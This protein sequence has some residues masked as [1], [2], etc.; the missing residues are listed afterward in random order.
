MNIFKRREKWISLKVKAFWI[1]LLGVLI[2]GLLIQAMIIWVVQLSVK[3]IYIEFAEDTEKILMS[4]LDQNSLKE[5]RNETLE[6]F[7][8]VSETAKDS[9]DAYATDEY[10]SLY[11]TLK[12][13]P[14]Y[15]EI[16]RV[17]HSFRHR[18]DFGAITIMAYD[19]D[20]GAFVVM[21]DSDYEKYQYPLGKRINRHEDYY[22]KTG[23][24]IEPFLRSL[25]AAGPMITHIV[26]IRDRNGKLL[27]YLSV[28]IKDRAISND[29]MMTARVTL[30][31]IFLTMVVFA[32][33]ISY[34]LTKRVLR[35]VTMLSEAARKYSEMDERELK[36]SP[37]VFDGI[38][39][40]NRD[41]IGDLLMSVR[42]MEHDIR[43]S[44][45]KITM[46]TA[47]Q[48]RLDTELAIAGQ[49]QSQMLPS[50]FPP[51]FPER[52]EFDLSA[53]MDSAKEVA[54]DFFDFFFIDHD[55]L[56]LVMADVSG[57]GIP[58]ALFMAGAK[59]VIRNVS[60]SYKRP[61]PGEILAEV[62]DILAE[63]NEVMVFVT[64]WLGILDVASG[65][66]T[67]ANGGHEYPCIY[68]K[69]PSGKKEFMLEKGVN[70]PGL[71]IFKGVEFEENE[72]ML[73][74][75][76]RIFVY[77]D[78]LPEA[79][80]KEEELFGMERMLKALNDHA[81]DSVADFLNRIHEEVDRFVGEAPQ[82]DDITMMVLEYKGS[83]D[84]L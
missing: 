61:T 26:P 24:P 52:K 64:V 70:G 50:V 58:A 49:I 33:S 18:G 4:L 60:R 57:K 47:E 44:V 43:S 40:R 76:D 78:G 74:K 10:Y 20:D 81:E 69:G 1:L 71:A 14:E 42:E 54:G 39:I 41:E 2:I 53:A 11:D 83:T 67:A 55:H 6:I 30:V 36:D 37:P 27:V 38:N 65:L 56:A 19:E 45:K 80:D 46:M 82:Y 62:N 63:G 75:G 59:T 34:I 16:M 29:T 48:E 77:T 7:N 13:K 25:E 5:I 9:M 32:L 79:Q 51:P 22:R 17:L 84:D 68:R 23:E 66:L 21:F 3:D 31:S 73:E 72:W 35:P 8:S 15:R 28:D 12:E